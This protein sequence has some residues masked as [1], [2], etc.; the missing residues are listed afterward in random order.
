MMEPVLISEGMEL[1][2]VEFQREPRGWVLRLY[3]DRDGGVTLDDCTAVSR[4]VGDL[5]D[6]EDLIDHAYHLEVSSPGPKRPLRKAQDFERFA[7]HQVKVTLSEP[8]DQGRSV[9]GVILGLVGDQ[10]RLSM[11]GGELEIPISAISKAR[12]VNP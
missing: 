8:G 6:V 2:E 10:L 12:L 4:E 3:I 1:V 9:S 7:G 5:L 11:D